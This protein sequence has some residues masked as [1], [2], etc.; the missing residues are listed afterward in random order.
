MDQVRNEDKPAEIRIDNFYLAAYLMT[1]GHTVVRVEAKDGK[2][3]IKWFIFADENSI[4][5]S[6]QKFALGNPPVLIHNMIVSLR[7]LKTMIYTKYE[8]NKKGASD[9]EKST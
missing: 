7:R 9:E 8:L 4:K 3:N 6:I 5:Q 1:I 2:E